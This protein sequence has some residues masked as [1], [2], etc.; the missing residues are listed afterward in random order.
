MCTIFLSRIGFLS[1]TILSQPSQQRKEGLDEGVFTIPE[2]HWAIAY[3]I[4]CIVV[5]VASPQE[6]E[7]ATLVIWVSP[8][9]LACI[10]WDIFVFFVVSHKDLFFWREMSI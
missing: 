8:Q 2:Q 1:K 6:E 3:A 9:T 5:E 10:F 4:G 7:R